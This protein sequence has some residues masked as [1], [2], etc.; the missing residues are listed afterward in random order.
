MPSKKERSKQRQK[1]HEKRQAKGEKPMEISDNV[2]SA[3][4]TVAALMDR[5]EV[6]MTVSEF[7]TERV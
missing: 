1:R 2:L 7:R 6:D 3:H 5:T 4:L